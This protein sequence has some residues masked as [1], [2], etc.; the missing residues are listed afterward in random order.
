MIGAVSCAGNTGQSEQDISAAGRVDEGGYLNPG[1]WQLTT[2][3]RH[4]YSFRH[5]IGTQEQVARVAQGTNVRNNINITDFILTYQA[6]PR[7]SFSA[8]VPLEIMSR[9]YTSKLF[10]VFRHQ[11]NAPAQVF[12]A[13]GIGDV[14]ISAQAWLWRP[15]TESSGNVGV[16]FGVKFPSGDPS[17][18][19]TVPSVSGP[20]TQV[21]DQSV[22]L[23]NGGWGLIVGTQAFKQVKRSIL[24][25]SGN[26][27]ISPQNRNGVQTGR[28]APLEA[29]M[30]VS[31][32]YLAQ[33]GVAHFVPK[34]RGLAANIG[35]RVEGVP[36]YDLVGSSDGF[37]RPGYAL[38]VEPGFE[39]SRGRNILSFSLPIAVL[40]DRSR[41]VP[42]RQNGGHGDA[43]FA[44]YLWLIS[45]TYRF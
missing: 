2:S 17:V 28:G 39:Y 44:D 43:A 20:S 26:Y 23:G 33:A 30:S 41:S 24:F 3:L 22:Q 16:S 19:N 7:W 31:D 34:V 21:L 1:R 14:S 29:I 13:N 10:E 40:R 18:I 38:S 11:P 6:N 37:R 9:T 45:Y 35:M 32:S 25:F 8:D 5:F 27:L 15:P 4:Q 12:H 36:V 42:D